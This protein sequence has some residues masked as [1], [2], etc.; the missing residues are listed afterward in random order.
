MNFPCIYMFAFTACSTL[1][2]ADKPKSSCVRARLVLGRKS[3]N[4][5][6]NSGTLKP[7]RI[8]IKYRGKTSYLLVNDLLTKCMWMK[9]YFAYL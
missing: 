7:L 4:A 8:K 6:Y 5:K 3:F 2:R 1:N 9:F